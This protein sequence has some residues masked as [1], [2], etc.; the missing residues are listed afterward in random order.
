V[1]KDTAKVLL[2]ATDTTALTQQTNVDTTLINNAIL[3]PEQCKQTTF[4]KDELS[5]NLRKAI[6]S[7][8]DVGRYV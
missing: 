1:Q 8:E 7:N 6:S 2:A 3:T 5:G 4:T